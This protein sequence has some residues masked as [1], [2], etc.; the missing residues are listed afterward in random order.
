[1]KVQPRLDAGLN[2]ELDLDLTRVPT[3][4]EVLAQLKETLETSEDC[5]SLVLVIVQRIKANEIPL[6]H[7]RRG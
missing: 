4:L 3:I 7:A 2:G 5:S 6:H 1:M